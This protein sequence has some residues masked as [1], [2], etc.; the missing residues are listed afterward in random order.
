MTVLFTLNMVDLH[1]YL[2]MVL[3]QILESYDVL[4]ELQDKPGDL[5][6]LKR[7]LAKKIICAPN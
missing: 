3:K 6:I 2:K 7:E 5:L 1:D 4:K